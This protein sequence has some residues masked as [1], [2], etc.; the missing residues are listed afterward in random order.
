MVL[1]R[2]KKNPVFLQCLIDAF[3]KPEGIVANF[4]ADTGIKHFV[5][6]IGIKH[7]V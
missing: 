4:T 6:C 1:H 7:I 2:E 3:S 5:Y